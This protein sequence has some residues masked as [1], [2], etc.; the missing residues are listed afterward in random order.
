VASGCATRVEPPAPTALAVPE[1]AQ[2]ATV[3]RHSDG[4]TFVLRGIG[5]GPLPA[6]PTKV[7]LLEVD[8]PEVSSPAACYGPE[9]ARRTAELLPKGARVRVE[10]DREERD[11]YGRVLLYVWTADGA[12]VEEVLLREG[13][14]RVLF[15][16]PNDRH[17][18]HFR[19]VE[20]QARRDRVGLWGACSGGR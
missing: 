11:R 12:S 13:Y 10:A 9:A 15:V 8:T 2:E 17:L 4:D 7:R 1:R 5:V 19:A 14:A 20:A 6:A 3:V 18:A 16:R